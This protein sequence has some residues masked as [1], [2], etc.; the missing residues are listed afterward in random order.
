VLLAPTTAHAAYAPKLEV[1][2]DPTT[3]RAA[4]AV[5]STITQAS[6]ETAS[7]T[8]K[9]AFPKG[10]S[11]PTTAVQLQACTS[12]QEANR[13]CP[14][15]SKMGTAEAV[16]S[17]GGN[18][19]GT[20]NYG[21][22]VNG[23]TKLIVF[24]SNGISLFDQT[25]EGFVDI[26]PN[27]FVTT[28]D[29]LPNVLTTSFVLK[30]DGEPRSLLTNPAACGEYTF[31]ADFTSQ[32]GERATSSSPVEITDCPPPPLRIDSVGLARSKIRRGRTTTLRIELSEPASIVVT[33][34]RP[35]GARLKTYALEGQ[36]GVNR[37]RGIGKRLRAGRYRIV[38]R[39]TTA[40]GRKA[41]TRRVTLRIV[42]R[43]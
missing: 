32:Q 29:N 8:V 7:K 39:A 20:V 18:F 36:A 26:T 12:D 34:R 19:T 24:L 22:F 15:E 13:A 42:R 27:G 30:L 33:V 11:P 37:L 23:R 43:A 40:D 41:G 2:I 25:I 28:F 35:S 1:Q 10:F 14:P 17:P 3:P 21:G 31:T 38:V 9:V 6:N 4:P 16:A 5:T